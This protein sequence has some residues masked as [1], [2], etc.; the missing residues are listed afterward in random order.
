MLTAAGAA[1]VASSGAATAIDGYRN[2]Q[3]GKAKATANDDSRRAFRRAIRAIGVELVANRDTL[4]EIE[5]GP[6]VRTSNPLRTVAWTQHEG[7]LLDH[8]DPEPYRVGSDVYREL[9]AA[10]ND[11]YLFSDPTRE[12]QPADITR[13]EDAERAIAGE[14]IGPVEVA[15]RRLTDLDDG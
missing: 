2:R 5:S 15:I 13:Y 6:F 1:L 7:T 4:R 14:L 8:P 3:E 10:D 11:W 9:R 12:H